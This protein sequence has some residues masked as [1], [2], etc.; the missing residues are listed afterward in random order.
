[1]LHSLNAHHLGRRGVVETSGN[2]DIQFYRMKMNAN[3]L[4]HIYFRGAVDTVLPVFD[5]GVRR[6]GAMIQRPSD[7]AFPDRVSSDALPAGT[8]CEWSLPLL[9]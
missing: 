4:L 1:M 2:V 7:R 8:T 6:H 9:S 5:C 3:G